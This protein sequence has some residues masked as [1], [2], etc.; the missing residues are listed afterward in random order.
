MSPLSKVRKSNELVQASYKLSLTGQ[1]VFILLLTKID[2]SKPLEDSYTITSKEYAEAYGVDLKNA[3]LALEKGISELYDTDLRIRNQILKLIRRKRLANEAIYY[4]GQGKVS[5]SFPES[6][7]PYLCEF[8]KCYTMY[9]IGQVA[10]LKSAYSIRLYELLIQ[11][12][13][14]GDRCISV[15]DFRSCLGVDENK[16]KR[17][18][19]FKCRVIEPA[20]KELNLR[21]ALNVSWE[22]IKNSKKIAFLSF[23]FKEIFYQQPHS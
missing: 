14:T 5:I 7:A 9:K 12:R 23:T 11:F 19:N 1:R 16:Y 17:F 8:K 10:G 6:M 3:Y 20:V 4:F 13:K 22:G 2:T 21:T 15:E 18:N